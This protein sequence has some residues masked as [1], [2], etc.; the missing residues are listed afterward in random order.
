MKRNEN[1][2]TVAVVRE[3]ERES[4]RVRKNC[5]LF[6]VQ[7]AELKEY[8]VGRTGYREKLREANFTAGYNENSKEKHSK[9]IRCES[10]IAEEYFFRDVDVEDGQTETYT[11]NSQSFLCA[12]ENGVTLTVLVII[13]VI[14]LILS[15]V[16][17]NVVMGD[18]GL[19]Q[20]AQ[21]QKNGTEGTIKS[22]EEDVNR[23]MQEYA[24]VMAEDSEFTPPTPGEPEEPSISDSD[25]QVANYADVDGNGSVD[26]IIYADL[27]IGGS[28]TGLGQSYTI[29]TSSNF[30]KYKVTQESYLGS[31]GTGQV[32]A[33][34]DSSSSSGTER[35][36]VM[37]LT[38]VD[39]RRNGTYYTWYD[40]ANGNMDDYASTT[41][42]A[43]GQGEQNTINMIVKWNASDYG[44]Q[45][46]HSSYTDMWGIS[47]VNSRTWNGSEGW[48]IPSRDEWAAF[49]GELNITSSNYADVGLSDYCWSSSQYT[50]YNV[51]RAYF[52]L[53]NFGNS[54]VDGNLYVRL[55]TTF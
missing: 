9:K 32:I 50:S 54:R 10:K 51:W 13:V 2:I 53:G 35:F 7:K 41:S 49:A 27:A 23:I 31:F 46:D 24:N 42:T 43:F 8:I 15:T 4:R 21:A 20:T 25:T 52:F 33:P 40:A 19:I 55:G 34:L 5:S 48:Y 26:G 18:G 14:L 22:E 37:A 28:G 29:P 44:A 39:G 38:D 17:I 11:E 16:T 45:N 12:K 30:K 47:T 6:D 3:R 36:Y 1:D